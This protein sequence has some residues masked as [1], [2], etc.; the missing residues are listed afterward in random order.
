MCSATFSL[1]EAE[2]VKQALDIEEE[3]WM[4]FDP[5]PAFIGLGDGKPNINYDSSADDAET[6]RKI[7]EFVV[8]NQSVPVLIFLEVNDDKV[9]CDAI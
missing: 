3:E 8:A 6:K 4:K 5:A 2:I 1:L 7:S 9:C